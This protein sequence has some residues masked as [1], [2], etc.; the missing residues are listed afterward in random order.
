VVLDAGAAS[1][2][3]MILIMSDDG[4]LKSCIV[5]GRE[6]CGVLR[7]P[8]AVAVDQAHNIVV[9]DSA[10]RRVLLFAANGKFHRQ[11]IGPGHDP[12]TWPVGLDIGDDGRMFV[13]AKGEKFAEV[14]VFSYQ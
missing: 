9:S 6:P 12:K 7:Q 5:P 2:L 10:N 3:G 13:V 14:R 4:Y 1:G 11:L 8:H